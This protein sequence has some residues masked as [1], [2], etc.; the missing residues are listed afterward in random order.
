[1]QN[2]SF[3]P[4]SN[5]PWFLRVCSTSLLKTLGKR[6]NFSFSRS[7]FYLFGG[8]SSIFIKFEIVIQT[9]SVWKSQRF[10][11]RER[12]KCIKL[13]IAKCFGPCQSARIVQAVLGWY[14]PQMHLTLFYNAWL[15][16]LHCVHKNNTKTI[17][18]IILIFEVPI[19]P[20]KKGVCLQN[21][22]KSHSYH[23]KIWQLLWL[24]GY[25]MVQ[26]WKVPVNSN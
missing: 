7:V 6:F 18:S 15:T 13:E 9:F 19:A 17:D 8:L 20:N 14:P 2:G 22:S 21:T 5:K 10:V 11:I 26:F 25:V 16:Y 23:L 1:M 24:H 3:Y 4:F 12:V